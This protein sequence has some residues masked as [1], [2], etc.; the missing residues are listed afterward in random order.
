[1]TDSAGR[2]WNGDE[3]IDKATANF[4]AAE[5][6]PPVV[7]GHPRENAPAYGWVSGLRKTLKHGRAVLEARLSQVVPEFEEAVRRGLYKKR[8][9]SFYPDG[10]LRHVGFLGATPPAIKGLADIA[11]EEGEEIIEFIEQEKPKME[12]KDFIEA[13]K[14]WKSEIEPPKAGQTDD[15]NFSEADLQARV[16]EALKAKEAEFAEREA[17][18]KAAQGVN[19]RIDKLVSD[20]KV[21]PA[22]VE[23]GLREFVEAIDGGATEINFNEAKAKPS[24]MFFSF[25]EKLGGLGLFKETAT[26][27][28]AS[29]DF[30]EA[31][32][33]EE[34]GRRIAA[35]VAG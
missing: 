19:A 33:D 15:K 9:A 10:R 30:K 27:D 2:G 28:A 5:H 34:L 11:F 16:D 21:P 8:S 17:R 13:L 26:K 35:K 1:M 32:T 31:E 20:G 23:M 22:L 24:E 29:A 3:L 7:I 25:L 18:M 14:F 12:M 4:N 6:E